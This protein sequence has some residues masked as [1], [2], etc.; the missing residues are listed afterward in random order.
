MKAFSSFNFNLKL[1]SVKIYKCIWR[2]WWEIS[3]GTIGGRGGV[4]YFLWAIYLTAF[5][6]TGSNQL[7][8]EFR[9]AFACMHLTTVDVVSVHFLFC[10]Y[11]C[12]KRTMCQFWIVLMNKD[13]L[14][15]MSYVHVDKKRDVNLKW[16]VCT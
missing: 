3:T 1:Y 16:R 4:L 6:T 8:T 11:Y 7:R 2:T 15:A 5:F 10:L 9:S 12:W 13:K 14:S